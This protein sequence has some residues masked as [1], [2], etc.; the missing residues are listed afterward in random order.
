MPWQRWYT[1]NIDNFEVAANQRFNLPR[2]LVPLSAT[3]EVGGGTADDPSRELKIVHLNGML[4]DVPER[5]TFSLTQYAERLSRHDPWYVR[6]AADLLTS[7]VVFIGTSLEESP[8]WQ[9]IVMR[10]GRGA[11]AFTE[12]RHRSYLV[13]PELDRAR[14]TLLAQYNVMWMPLTVEQF[15]KDIL[16]EMQPSVT[17]GFIFLGKNANPNLLDSPRIPEVTELATGAGEPHE[18]LLGQEPTWTDIQSDRAILRDCDSSLL[19][20]VQEKLSLKEERGVIAIT[21]TAGSGKSTSLKRLCLKLVSAGVRVGWIDKRMEI[22]TAAIRTAMKRDDAPQILAIDDADLLGAGLSVLVRD[23]SQYPS[24]PLIIIAVRSSRIDRV[25]NPAALGNIAI[26]E[27]VMPHLTDQDID[28]LI[29]LLD[30][31]NRLGLLT[32]KTRKEQVAAFKEVAGRQLLVAM[33]KAT[34]GQWLEDK[35]VDELT[36]LTPTG[37]SIYAYIAVAAA[38]R[39]ILTRDEVL[40]ALGDFSNVAMN[41]LDQLVKRHVIIANDGEYSARHRMIAEIIRDRL[42]ETG[43]MA[44]VVRGLGMIAA[45]KTTPASKRHDR[46]MRMLQIFLNHD[47]LLDSLG[48]DAAKNLYSALEDPLAWSFHYWLQR[49]SLEVERG[50]LKVAENFLGSALSLAPDDPF[51]RTEWA[52]L[53]FK[54]AVSN[55]TA[56]ESTDLVKEATDNLKGLI[57]SGSANQY[58]YHVLGSQGLAWARHAIKDANRRAGYLYEL[59]GVL[60]EGLKKHP[61]EPE[62]KELHDVL[63]REYLGSAVRN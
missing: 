40:I 28:A 17:S 10:R 58:P 5:V 53:Q 31:E 50:S 48:I 36:G 21:G 43:Q 62:L 9:H 47:L 60:E 12:F 20:L 44:P 18:F 57:A 24:A 13:V 19:K 56:P 25:M 14:R 35:A 38:Y 27:R 45:A 52:Y 6:F 15:C 49:G 33:I 29:D 7:P 2:R 16:Q 51:V 42:H 55:P 22:A 23:V 59:V 39:F 41:E 3:G 1:L 34:S 37:A 4:D 46:H 61:R 8:L 54:K 63:K 26:A 11:R 32:G 30:R